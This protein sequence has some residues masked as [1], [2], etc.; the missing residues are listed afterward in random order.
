MRL[1]YV[2][3]ADVVCRA[4]NISPATPARIPDN[5]EVHL[6]DSPFEKSLVIDL[7]APRLQG[8][9]V[10]GLAASYADIVT[11]CA[12]IQ[13]RRTLSYHLCRMCED[14]LYCVQAAGMARRR[15][16]EFLIT[17]LVALGLMRL[18]E[19]WRR[20]K[21]IPA[22]QG[23]R[24]VGK[25]QSCFVS[26]VNVLQSCCPAESTVFA[27]RVTSAD[28]AACMSHSCLNTTGITLG[29]VICQCCCMKV[30]QGCY[31]Y[32]QCCGLVLTPDNH[33]SSALT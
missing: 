27:V 25:S 2:Q 16:L 21:P 8:P 26:G 9:C 12:S 4:D 20:P 30:C 33:K 6:R 18:Y 17:I 13:Q 11:C 19:V 23:P 29:N 7:I 22:I 10:R 31:L 24:W 28:S 5:S 32:C 1:L 15:F 14:C 3:V